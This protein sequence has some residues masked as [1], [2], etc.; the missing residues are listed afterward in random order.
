M[1]PDDR[2]PLEVAE[3]LFAAIEAGDIEV[4]H[5]LYA[6]DVEIWRNTDGVVENR[7]RNARR[8]RWL[9]RHLRHIRYDVLRRSPIDGGF[10]QQHVLRAV[11]AA[12]G[13]V[14]VPGCIVATCAG[15][16]ITRLDEYLDSAHI[17][18]LINSDSSSRS[19]QGTQP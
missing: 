12:G 3:R 2:E 19:A 5:A 9:V 16:R 15:G 8:L 17:A 10:V 7:D 14:V 6:P 13:A 18:S 4:V 1:V 11:D